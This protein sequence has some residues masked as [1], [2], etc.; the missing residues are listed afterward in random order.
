MAQNCSCLLRKY[1][2]FAVNSCQNV[3]LLHWKLSTARSNHFITFLNKRLPFS[4][5]SQT[6]P[7]KVMYRQKSYKAL[8]KYGQFTYSGPLEHIGMLGN[9]PP[10]PPF[11]SYFLVDTLTLSQV[12]NHVKLRGFS[13]DTLLFGG[14]WLWAWRIS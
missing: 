7:T 4:Q 10:P 3:L 1:C 13:K 11:P 5:I 6:L 14:F 8:C 12:R 9:L 2:F